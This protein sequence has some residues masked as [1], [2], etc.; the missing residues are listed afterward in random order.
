[1]PD[2]LDAFWRLAA[3]DIANGNGICTATLTSGVQLRGAVSI[4][5]SDFR[6]LFLRTQTGWHTIAYEAI[7]AITGEKPS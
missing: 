2:D 1:M 6:T 3:H 4:E 7:A 5:M